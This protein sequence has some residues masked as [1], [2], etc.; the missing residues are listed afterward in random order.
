MS[1]H[2]ATHTAEVFPPGGHEVVDP[3]LAVAAALKFEP[4]ELQDFELADKVA[5]QMMGKLLGF[6]FCVLVTLMTGV[7]I[8]MITHKAQGSDPQAPIAA[9]PAPGHH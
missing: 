5:G 3:R 9:Q 4:V 8:W 2:A 1:E 7:N 6:L